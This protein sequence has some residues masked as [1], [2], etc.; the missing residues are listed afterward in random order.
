MAIGVGVKD[1]EGEFVLLAV[2]G[3]V[4]TAITEDDFDLR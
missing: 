4:S 2:D 3:V 1:E